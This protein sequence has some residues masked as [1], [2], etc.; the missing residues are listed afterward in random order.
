MEKLKILAY[1]DA[2]YCTVEERTRSVAGK[3]VFLSNENEKDVNPLYWKSKTIPQVSKST[4]SAETR[5]MD[6][7]A[8]DAVD[9]ARII[10]QI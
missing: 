6:A 3:M 4:K 7:Y 1:C 9:L 5:A 2:S 8:D 10:K